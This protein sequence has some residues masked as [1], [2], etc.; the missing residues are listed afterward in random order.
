MHASNDAIQAQGGWG[1]PPGGG[2]YGPPGGA[3]PGG[4][5]GPPGGGY[6]APPGGFGGP[7]G[8]GFGGPP[9][10]G[11]GG[12]PGGFGG[13]PFGAPPPGGDFGAPKGGG[14][15]GGPG[16]PPPPELQ[17]Q[18]NTWFILSITSIFFGCCLGGILAT[19]LTH[20]AKQAFA[21]GNYMEAQSKLGTAKI[22]VII[23]FVLGAL[24]L[25][26]NILA[27]L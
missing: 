24:G 5:G 11:F 1:P 7:P 10:G 26:G 16:G 18:L 2:G 3:P 13:A 22:V 8:G 9:G 6:G 19:V 25:V 14:F 15:G 17:G 20:G 4:F 21:A 23:G 12:P 27:Q